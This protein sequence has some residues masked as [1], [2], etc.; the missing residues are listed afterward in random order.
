MAYEVGVCPEEQKQ[1]MKQIDPSVE[2]LEMSIA[3]LCEAL[4][5]DEERQFKL[6]KYCRENTEDFKIRKVKRH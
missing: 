4:K 1:F 5:L 3:D 2:I 6:L